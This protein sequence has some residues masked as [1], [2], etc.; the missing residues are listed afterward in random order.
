MNLNLTG[1]TAFISGST[2]GIG[3]AIAESLAAEGAQVIINGRSAERVDSAVTKLREAYPETRISGVAA[4]LGTADGVAALIENVE[5]VDILINNMGIFEPK[6]LSAI[7]DE[8]WLKFFEVN[9]LSGIRLSRHYMPKMKDK[10]W[11]RIIFISSESAI[12]IPAEMIHYGVTKT[13]QIAFARGM[14]ETLVGTNITVNSVLPGPTA[15]EG[16][17]TFVEQMASSQNI[18]TDEMEKKFFEEERGTSLIKRFSSPKEIADVVA[19]VSSPL[20]SSINGSALRVEGGVIKS[21]F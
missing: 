17:E 19:F 5:A 13:A 1:K 4:D 8:D 6:E 18:S 2:G 20:A 7:T 3:F 11:G 12:Q 10:N 15:S 9:V 14:A 21:A 16:V